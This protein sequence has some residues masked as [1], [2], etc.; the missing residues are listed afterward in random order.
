VCEEVW[1]EGGGR[2]DSS[3]SFSKGGRCWFQSGA[4]QAQPLDEASQPGKKPSTLTPSGP[5]TLTPSQQ[6]CCPCCLLLPCLPVCCLLLAACC[7][8]RT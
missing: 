7:L 2:G 8:P 3:S 1:Q 6:L 5:S 4:V